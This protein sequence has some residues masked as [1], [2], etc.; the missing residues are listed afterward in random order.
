MAKLLIYR[1][2]TPHAEVELPTA[3][4][5]IGRNA[6]NDIVLEDPSKGVSRTHAEI[7]FEGGHHVLVDRESQNGIWVS[8]S[9]VSS[10]VLAPH[11]V[12]SVGPFR[13]M[14]EAPAPKA[15]VCL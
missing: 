3:T 5:R 15:L 8:G 1:G 10:V 4:V 13:L 2:Q 11:V 12:A 14:I 6:Q 9:R 7:R